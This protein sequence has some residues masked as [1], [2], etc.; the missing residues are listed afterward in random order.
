MQEVSY[1]DF[2]ERDECLAIWSKKYSEWTKVVTITESSQSIQSSIIQGT[3]SEVSSAI[4][5][6]WSDAKSNEHKQCLTESN[7]RGIECYYD[8]FDKALKSDFC[9]AS[10]FFV[11]ALSEDIGK[12]LPE[13]QL[14]HPEIENDSLKHANL[15]FLKLMSMRKSK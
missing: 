2:R 5:K 8:A 9:G 13:L 1:E 10:A 6:V 4:K 14:E 12:N 3:Q 15:F 11:N 7:N